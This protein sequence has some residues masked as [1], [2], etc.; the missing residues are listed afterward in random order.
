MTPLP[1]TDKDCP[2]CDGTFRK[3]GHE[4]ICATCQ[5]SPT[6]DASQRHEEPSAWATHQA[7]V[8]RRAY[9]DGDGRPRLVGGYEDAYW[10]TGAYSFDVDEGSFVV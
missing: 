4:L 5:H 3:D 6:T 10:G 8:Y 2:L 9:G 1:S 7:Q